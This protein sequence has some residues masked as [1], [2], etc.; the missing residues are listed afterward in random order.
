MR[1]DGVGP[2]AL[3]DFEGIWQIDRQIDDRRAGLVITG[4]GQARLT[5]QG[6]G[7]I[8]DET[9]MLDLPGQGALTA[10]RRYLWA[11]DPGGVA[12]AFDDGRPF[13]RILLSGGD[14]RDRHH[15]DPD[16][17]DVTYDFSTWPRW[18]ARWDVTGPRKGYV[19][20]TSY[21]RL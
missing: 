6:D 2:A 14:A 9:L 20:R 4:T 11:Q 10:E 19:M 21:C 1:A 12:V 16:L 8:Y 5:R 13:H 15:C 7:L 3:W 17:Y 18:S